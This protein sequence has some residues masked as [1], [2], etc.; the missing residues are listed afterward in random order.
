MWRKRRLVLAV[1]AFF[2]LTMTLVAGCGRGEMNAPRLAQ[3]LAGKRAVM[4]VAHRGFRDE[5]LFEPKKAVEGRGARVVVASSSLEEARGMLGGTV[6]PDLLLKNVRAA[7]YDAVIF[8]GG[9]GAGEY[10]DG[11]EAYRVAR[12]ALE[13][14]KVLGAICLAPVTLANAGVLSGRKATVW[15][16]EAARLEAAG[17]EY[18]GAPV[19]IDGR[20]VTASGPESAKEFG[21]AVA[22]LLGG[23]APDRGGDVER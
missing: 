21:E 4:I 2:V 22:R 6:K 11:P 17:A 16:D 9:E 8:V 7:D 12:E 19:E 15:P 14:G 3:S 13:Q 18:T 10:W 23:R 20:V 5:E 1:L